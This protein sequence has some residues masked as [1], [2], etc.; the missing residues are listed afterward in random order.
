MK[1][2][3]DEIAELAEFIAE[4]NIT[5]GAVN[6]EKIAKQRNIAVHYDTFGNYF[7]GMLQYEDK[8]FDIFINLDKVKNKKYSRARFTLAHE[9]GHYFIDNHRNVLKK[10]LSLSYDKDL[11][12]YSNNPIEK[13]ANHFATNLLMPRERF[14]R[15]ASSM[16][17]GIIAVKNIAKEFKTSIT[18]TAIQ[19]QNL[20]K[21]PCG[22]LYWDK[23]QE[24]KWNSGFRSNFRKTFSPNFLIQE[25]T[26]TEI[27]ETFNHPFF[28]P[29]RSTITANLSSFYPDVTISGPEDKP[30]KVETMN[31]Q[32][33][34]F[35]SFV[36][37]NE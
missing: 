24:F 16:D 20:I 2:S 31:L 25:K 12:Y 19:Y 33:Y 4:E 9:L 29:E 32:G 22:L 1:Q 36:F 13:E 23:N 15:M 6:L 27:F 7:T 26:R 18:S 14:T 37:V 35:L 17:I 5:R 3:F 34:G 21:R 10:G 30:L 8:F 28:T 11:H